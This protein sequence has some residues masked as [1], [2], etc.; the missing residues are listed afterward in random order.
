M[1]KPTLL[2]F[3][4]LLSMSTSFVLPAVAQS[5][6]TG[7]Q[8][9][10]TR[11]TNSTQI[12]IP[13]TAALMV[14]FV[15]PIQMDVGN[16]STYP[17]TLPLAQA[18]MDADG[19]IIVPEGTPVILNLKPADKGAQLVAQGLVVAGQVVPVQATSD[20]IPAIKVVK[21][22]TNDKAAENGS[23][24]G[25][26]A[27]SAMGFL[28]KGDPEKFDRGAMLGSA[29]GILTG[30]FSPKETDWILQIPQDTVH[31]LKL[32]APLTLIAHVPIQQPT[33]PMANT[34]TTE[35]TPHR[36][37]YIRPQQRLVPH[38]AKQGANLLR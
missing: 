14:K 30:L 4:L 27:G 11:T 15:Q 29:G 12:T 34:P 28:G 16:Q 7:T 21:M 31:T 22:R 33:M 1:K 36:T 20:V 2:N 26:L 38:Q 8:P 25:R 13:Q 17:L 35:T 37:G 19:N 10:I 23:I 24:F 9:S 5:T 32:Q 6:A 18:L 3:A